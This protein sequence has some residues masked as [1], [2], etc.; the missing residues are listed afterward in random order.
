MLSTVGGDGTV[1]SLW[2]LAL[3]AFLLV[4]VFPRPTSQIADSSGLLSQTVCPSSS[5]HS[6]H[7]SSSIVKDRAGLAAMLDLAAGARIGL[8]PQKLPYSQL[9]A[10]FSQL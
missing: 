3:A 2:S 8:Q 6:T 4:V 5:N 7:A 9:V 10:A 1:C